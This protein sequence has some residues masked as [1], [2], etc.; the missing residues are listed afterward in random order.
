M[1]RP[2]TILLLFLAIAS[3]HVHAQWTQIADYPGTGAFGPVAFTI[4]NRA[5]VGMGQGSNE[6]WE[7]NVDSDTWTRRADLPGPGRAWAFGFAIDGKGYVGCGDPQANLNPVD[8]FYMYDPDTDTWMQKAKFTFL[9]RASLYHFVI[10]GKAYVGGGFNQ[11]GTYGDLVMYTPETDTWTP[12]QGWPG[13]NIRSA[14]SFVID[15]KGYV[16]GGWTGFP[17]EGHSEFYAYDPTQNKWTRIADYPGEGRVGPVSFVANGMG[18]VGGGM[19]ADFNSPALFHDFHG[20]D[21]R[22]DTWTALENSDLPHN[23]TLWNVGFSINNT[24]YV[25][26]GAFIPGFVPS[27]GWYKYSFGTRLAVDPVE[28]THD[29]GTVLAGEDERVTYTLRNAGPEPIS[30][31]DIFITGDADGVFSLVNDA[32]PIAL[33]PGETSLVTLTFAPVE[34]KDHSATLTFLSDAENGSQIEIALMG[35]GHLP[36]PIIDVGTSE[37]DFGV[38]AQNGQ[39]ELTL[40]IENTGDEPLDVTGLSIGSDPDGVFS[41]VDPAVPFQVDIGLTRTVTVQFLPT[42]VKNYSGELVIESNAQNAPQ[43]T[44]DLVGESRDQILEIEVSLSSLSFSSVQAGAT[45]KK[46]LEIRNIGEGEIV[47]SELEFT[48]ANPDLFSAEGITL[49]LSLQGGETHTFDVVFAPD[50]EG[51]FTAELIVRSNAG[52]DPAVSVSLAGSGFIGDVSAIEFDPNPLDFGDIL[53]GESEQRTIAMKSTGAKGLEV[54]SV[55]LTG[56]DAFQMPGAGTPF[57]MLVGEIRNLNITYTPT[58][59]GTHTATLTVESD[60]FGSETVTVDITAKAVN[61]VSE[62]S[63]DITGIDFGNVLL[64]HFLEPWHAVELHLFHIVQLHRAHTA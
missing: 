6:F 37:L 64:H 36:V 15:G 49:P 48:G 12:M 4:G 31:T 13:G 9:A 38:V 56:S 58:A 47:V 1:Q 27:V 45:R 22:T 42:E 34:S 50:N 43:Y 39:K 14:T 26:S 2:V 3:T 5:F 18:F 51:S 55:Q 24:A 30:V 23:F 10:D 32:P 11:N 35:E 62:V 40:S 8:D 61:P 52:N 7:Y 19:I 46:S 29:F 21:P 41:I 54:Y 44:V 63:V 59:E 57:L 25:G 28:S 33:N 17:D 53:V 60:A 20:Y 16:G